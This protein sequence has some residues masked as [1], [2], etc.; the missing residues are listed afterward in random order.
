MTLTLKQS[1]KYFDKGNIDIYSS[2]EELIRQLI[3][4]GNLHKHKSFKNEHEIRITTMDNKSPYGTEYALKEIG[5]VVKKTSLDKGT[6][7]KT[8]ENELPSLTQCTA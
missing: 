3:Y 7:R 5:N 8:T 4:A 2:E 1:K 6:Q